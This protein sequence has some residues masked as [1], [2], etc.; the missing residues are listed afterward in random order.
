MDGFFTLIF[1]RNPTDKLGDKLGDK[2]SKNESKIFHLI[3]E[4]P[5]IKIAEIAKTLGIS[6]TAIGNNIKK[7]KDK[8][9]IRREG[10]ERNGFFTITTN[11]KWGEKWGEKFNKNEQN[12][13]IEIENNPHITQIPI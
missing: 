11:E 7:L 5:T 1:K 10:S 8:Q 12:I 2:L 13:L 9:L 6:A 4:K 3:K